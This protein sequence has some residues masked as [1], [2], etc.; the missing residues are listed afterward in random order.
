VSDYDDNDPIRYAFLGPAYAAVAVI[1][2]NS[3]TS[4]GQLEALL[5]EASAGRK[6]DSESDF[7]ELVEVG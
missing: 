3:A 4:A 7:G 1:P 5:V 6:G 2:G